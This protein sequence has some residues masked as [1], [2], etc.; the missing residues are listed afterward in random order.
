MR[1]IA[2][3]SYIPDATRK[4]VRREALQLNDQLALRVRSHWVK[5]GWHPPT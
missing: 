4:A 3:V 2:S 5:A 1:A